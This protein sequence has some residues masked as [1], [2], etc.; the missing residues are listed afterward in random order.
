LSII[1]VS[2]FGFLTEGIAMG[3]HLVDRKINSIPEF[4]L[5]KEG[6]YFNGLSIHPNGSDW[7]FGEC[8]FDSNP[9][10]E[11]FILKF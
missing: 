2:Q 4:E 1:A 6:R 11:C 7:L 10:G 8:N 9:D 5:Q 3:S